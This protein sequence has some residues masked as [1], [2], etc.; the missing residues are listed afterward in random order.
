[1]RLK[2]E[3]VFK[4]NQSHALIFRRE[5][6][7]NLWAHGKWKQDSGYETPEEQLGHDYGEYEDTLCEFFR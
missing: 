4:F 5:L 6:A 1:M 7:A 2:Q 3:D